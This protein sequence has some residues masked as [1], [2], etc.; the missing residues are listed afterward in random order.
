LPI[1]IG[2]ARRFSGVWHCSPGILNRAIDEQKSRKAL[3]FMI[4]QLKE[5]G[6]G[7]A[8]LGYVE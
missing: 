5:I 8:N 1:I 3:D 7:C 2:N 4:S 6:I